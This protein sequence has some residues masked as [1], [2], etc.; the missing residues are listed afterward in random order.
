MKRVLSFARIEEITKDFWALIGTRQSFPCDIRTAI[1][2]T[3]PLFI[4]DIPKLSISKIQSYLQSRGISLRLKTDSK[5]LYGFTLIRK[6][7]GYIF[8]NGSDTECEKRFTLAHELAHYL[9]DYFLPRKKAVD[10]FGEHILEVIDGERKPTTEERIHSIISYTSL[11][12][13]VHILDRSE[14]CGLD[15]MTI[16][17]CEEEADLLALEIL[18]PR[19][20]VLNDIATN[21]STGGRNQNKLLIDKLLAEKY[22]LPDS[23]IPAYSSYLVSM[24][25]G[26]NSICEE[27]GIKF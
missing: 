27:W 10:N 19:E 13:Y 12:L 25:F 7:C 18:A 2:L 8:V 6:D 5:N 17:K 9:L 20:Y 4:I 24:F 11:S 22:G 26:R 1:S 21:L 14:I 3:Q 23:I 15:R 16:W